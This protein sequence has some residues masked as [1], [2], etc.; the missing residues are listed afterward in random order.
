MELKYA[1]VDDIK[2]KKRYE[3]SPV[4]ILRFQILREEQTNKTFLCY[5]MKNIG[6]KVI[7]AVHFSIFCYDD[8]DNKVDEISAFEYKRVF[9]KEGE[10]F[11][12][13]RTVPLSSEG[14]KAKKFDLFINH[15]F[16]DDKTVWNSKRILNL[17]HPQQLISE[18]PDAEVMLFAC[19]K[20]GI[21]K[22]AKYVPDII[23][24]FWRCTCGQMNKSNANQCIKCK[25]DKGL[26]NK[27]FHKDYLEEMQGKLEERKKRVREKKIREKNRWIQRK[28]EKNAQNI[29]YLCKKAAPAFLFLFVA[30]LVIFLGR[31][32]I[33]PAYH[34][35][36][37]KKQLDYGQYVMAKQQFEKSRQYKNSEQ[38]S[39]YVSALVDLEQ[40]KDEMDLGDIYNKV[41]EL[42]GFQGANMLLGDNFYLKQIKALQ[43]KWTLYEEGVKKTYDIS[44]GNILLNKKNV[45]RILAIGR[46]IGIQSGNRGEIAKITSVTKNEMTAKS[47]SS[48]KI[49]HRQEIGA[50]SIYFP[51]ESYEKVLQKTLQDRHKVVEKM[52]RESSVYACFNLIQ[53]LYSEGY[54]P[55]VKLE[56]AYFKNL[57]EAGKEMLTDGTTV[58]YQKEIYID[59]KKTV[60]E[61]TTG[62]ENGQ[63]AGD[64][65]VS[66]HY[67]GYFDKSG[68]NLVAYNKLE[69]PISSEDNN[70]KLVN[71]YNSYDIPNA[72]IPICK[73][74]IETQMEKEGYLG[75]NYFR[76]AAAYVEKSA[77]NGMIVHIWGND[78]SG[79]NKKIDGVV[80]Y[81][82]QIEKTSS[83]AEIFSK[84]DHI[85][86]PIY[87][88]AVQLADYLT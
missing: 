54:A 79:V 14:A 57:E 25:T 11:A 16:Y 13:D 36:K 82:Y 85:G 21:V 43:G 63:Q 3:D 88:Y 22:Y 6:K 72:A 71:R 39:Q 84:N 49:F 9:A 29:K 45:Y 7:K 28:F 65:T 10:C 66:E 17:E 62:K 48:V 83:S 35:E 38:F 75:D 40:V 68:G 47:D 64:L 4:E 18:H 81:T 23:D 86:T 60:S 80:N 15:V 87:D 19:K 24:R 74:V 20:S 58:E 44:D 26:L 53:Y 61:K 12:H 70:K 50:S 2:A 32:I 33:L 30:A 56:R 1:V 41:V 52:K 37:G 55:F 69:V 34:Y 73:Q 67:V 42:D 76:V 8:S 46:G 77:T 27:V 51:V 59:V 78:A 31:E 5:T